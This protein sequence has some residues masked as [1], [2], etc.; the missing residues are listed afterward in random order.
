VAPNAHAYIS[1]HLA[2]FPETFG[3]A[4]QR[5]AYMNR[6]SVIFQAVD[7]GAYAAQCLHEHLFSQLPDRPEPGNRQT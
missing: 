4:W 5:N 2:I 7:C 3:W 1:G 6:S